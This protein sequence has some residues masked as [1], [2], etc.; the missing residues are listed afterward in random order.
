MNSIT[1]RLNSRTQRR[2]DAS[3]VTIIIVAAILFSLYLNDKDFEAE[4][5]LSNHTTGAYNY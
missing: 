4:Q 5:L 1:E 3:I 2:L